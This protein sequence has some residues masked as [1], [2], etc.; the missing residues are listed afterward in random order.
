MKMVG[1]EPPSSLLMRIILPAVLTGY[2]CNICVL[3]LYIYMLKN[4]NFK[5]F[6]VGH[7]PHLVYTWVRPWWWIMIPQYYLINCFL[8]VQFNFSF[9]SSHLVNQLGQNQI[10]L[11]FDQFFINPRGIDLVF[12]LAI[13]QQ[14]R[15]LASIIKI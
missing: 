9:N 8:L 5:K 15:A 3:L 14:T 2:R 11:I 10:K 1:L 12:A 7:G 4:S 13:L 6:E